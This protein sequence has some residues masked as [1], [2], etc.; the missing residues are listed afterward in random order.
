MKPLDKAQT[1]LQHLE[2]HTRT[3]QEMENQFA[4]QEYLREKELLTAVQEELK[5]LAREVGTLETPFVKVTVTSPAPK[6]SYDY[7]KLKIRATSDEMQAVWDNALK[8]DLDASQVANLVNAGLL[9][10][11]I[12]EEIKEIK[13]PTPAVSFKLK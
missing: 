8:F 6:I 4:V 7:D 13:Y 9:R 2:N 3:I 12:A 10:A 1:L 5:T 11:E